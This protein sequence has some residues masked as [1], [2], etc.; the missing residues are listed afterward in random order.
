[1][2]L[3][4]SD[5]RV[6][7][8]I[9]SALVDIL[10]H[11]TDEFIEKAGAV[12]GGMAYVDNRVIDEALRMA[13]TTPFFVPGGSACNTVIGVGR[14]GGRARFAGKSGNGNLAGIFES[15]LKTNNVE[16]FLSK[17]TSLTGR[18]LSII[19]P[20]AQRSMLTYLGASAEAKAE[21]ISPECFRGAAVAH[22]EGY[23][24]FNRELILSALDAASHAGARISLDLASFTVVQESKDFFAEIV[25]KYV[26]ILIANE[27]EARAF[28]GHSDEKSAI[29]AMAKHCRTAV[30]KL[31]ERGSLIAHEGSV[32]EI[33]PRLGGPAVDTTGA[34]DLWASG[35]LYGLVNGL[36]IEESGELGSL[37]GYEVCQ[38]VGAKIPDEGW[39][40]IRAAAGIAAPE[41]LPAARSVRKGPLPEAAGV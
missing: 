7:V 4:N 1:M 24:L 15:S 31:G 32:F 28:T 39:R 30:L 11:E 34:G 6:V 36:S 29:G 20:D 41:G 21:D 26:D 5:Q 16:P 13:S 17:S 27:D 14:L 8:G 18:V 37:C 22:V 40:R 10:V 25:K 38:V 35:F 23:L 33:A 9:G 19:T 2:V 3:P 12:K